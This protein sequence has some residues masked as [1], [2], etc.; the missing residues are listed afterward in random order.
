MYKFNYL[1]TSDDDRVGAVSS[2]FIAGRLINRGIQSIA[3]TESATRISFGLSDGGHVDFT[4]KANGAEIVYR[5]AD[6]K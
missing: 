4:L 3:T 5:S 1:V 2:D 6:K